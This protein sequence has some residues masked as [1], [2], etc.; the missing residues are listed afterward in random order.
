MK[1]RLIVICKQSA[2]D[3]EEML[4]H[5]A[6]KVLYDALVLW[7]W[8][9][10]SAGQRHGIFT[11]S[12]CPTM[13]H[14]PPAPAQPSPARCRRPAMSISHSMN[15]RLDRR[16]CQTPCMCLPARPFACADK[17]RPWQSRRRIPA[18]L[19]KTSHGPHCPRLE[20]EVGDPARGDPEGHFARG[21]LFHNGGARLKRAPDLA[22]PT[23]E[24]TTGRFG[25]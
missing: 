14:P 7:C 23:T 6:M 10:R 4:G 2:D 15:A 18:L 9:R 8:F 3:R 12:W 17:P 20:R 21:A 5:T 11:M 22:T 19:G 24:S 16:V 25:G 1:P 13:G